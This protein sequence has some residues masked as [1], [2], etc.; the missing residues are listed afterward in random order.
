MVVVGCSHFSG[1]FCHL[2]C[3]GKSEGLRE[4]PLVP[5][6]KTPST[7]THLSLFSNLGRLAP[8]DAWPSLEKNT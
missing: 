5:G 4:N 1:S 2:S 7:H 3:S 8:L 6:G